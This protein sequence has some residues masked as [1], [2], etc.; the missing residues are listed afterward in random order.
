MIR[1]LTGGVLLA[2]VVGAVWLAP[3]TW[4]LALAVLVAGLGSVEY[5]RL[6]ADLGAPVRLLLVVVITASTLVTM[7]WPGVSVAPVLM[8]AVLVAAADALLAG[9]PSSGRI[10][11]VAATGFAPLYLALPLGSLVSVHSGEGR[12]AVL[13]L[14]LT[15]VASDTCQYYAGRAFGRRPLAP[16]ISPKKTVEGAIGGVIGGTVLFVWL[17]G[18][19]LPQ[20]PPLVRVALGIALVLAGIVGD[21][22]E[23]LL[24]RTAEVKDSSQLIPGHGGVLDRIDALLFAA[25]V[26][27]VAVRY[28]STLAQ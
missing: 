21:L 19:W 23:S 13:L 8:S 5:S 17:G 15:V 14:L 22:F 4:L 6:C 18:L 16:A 3:S 24:K 28:G 7:A 25:P 27:F 2:A 9:R 26:Y 12:E 10:A 20:L 11:G 1:V